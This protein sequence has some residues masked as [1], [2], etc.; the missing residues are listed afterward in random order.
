MTVD[1]DPAAPPE[2][3]ALTVRDS[4]SMAVQL[5]GSDDPVLMTQRMGEI[6]NAMNAIVIERN[7]FTTIGGRKH[8]NIEGWSLVGSMVG[9]FPHTESVEVMETGHLDEEKIEKERRDGGTWIKTLPVVDGVIAYV[10]AVALRTADGRTVGRGSAMCSR[11]EEHWRDRDDNQLASMAQTRAAAKA[12]RLTFGYVMPMAGGDYSATPAEEM[13]GIQ[14][15][16][17]RS[18]NGGTR[19]AA[20]APAGGAANVAAPK[21]PITNLGGLLQYAAHAYGK[22]PPDV[23]AAFNLAVIGEVA[24]MVTDEYGGDWEQAATVMDAGWGTQAEDELE[25]A[26]EFIEVEPEPPEPAAEPETVAEATEGGPDYLAAAAEASAAGDEVLAGK[27]G[28]G[29]DGAE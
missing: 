16:P 6:A 24:K 19:P 5:W 20:A 9:A 15:E 25:E 22:Q 27:R 18:G 7:L 28:E 1:Q 3:T 10:A 14:P 17:R 8:V 11:R 13:D 23:A 26:A 12:Y 2:E 4:P 29:D 21:R